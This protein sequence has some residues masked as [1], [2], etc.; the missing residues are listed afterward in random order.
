MKMQCENENR[1]G[2]L[3]CEGTCHTEAHCVTATRHREPTDNKMS[4]CNSHHG[5]NRAYLR[6]KSARDK[7]KTPDKEGDNSLVQ[8]QW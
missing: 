8:T 3:A 2:K 4:V 6:F 5:R 7:I 1:L